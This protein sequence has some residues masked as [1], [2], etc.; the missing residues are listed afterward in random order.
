[1]GNKTV[2]CKHTNKTYQEKLNELYDNQFKL[3]SNIEEDKDKI[4]VECLRCNNN[5]EFSRSG[6]E[7]ECKDEKCPYC[8]IK[9]RENEIFKIVSGLYDNIIVN[10]ITYM[11]PEKFNVNFSCKKHGGSYDIIAK[12]IM[13]GQSLG[14][15][16]CP[17]C[18]KE[19]SNILRIERVQKYFPLKM[20]CG[21]I[22][23][24]LYAEI[25]LDTDKVMVHCVDQ[26]GYK[27][28]FMNEKLSTI[29]SSNYTS[30]LNKFFKR[31]SY[32]YENINNYCKINNID[33]KIENGNY[34][35]SGYAREKLPFK[36]SK[37]ETIITTWNAIQTSKLANRTD[38]EIVAIKN[39]KY[40]S[41]EKAIPI[42]LKK[43]KELK[44]PLLQ[45]DFEGIETSDNSIGIRVIWRIWGTFTNMIKELGL[46]EHDFYFK[47]N[48]K[49]YK[50]H[51][52]IM[53][54]IK[55]ACYEI[56]KENRKIIMISDLEKYTNM[57][58]NRLRKHCQK[59]G[60][61]LNKLVESYGY[62]IQ[63]TGNGMNYIFLDGEK[64]VS[65]YEYDF[66]NFLRENNL[67]YNK[68]YFRNIPYKTLDNEYSGNMNCDYLIILNNKK[69]YIELAGIL[70]NK[71]HQ[72]AYRNNIPIN[73][74]SKEI[75]R[76][77]LYQK[78]DIFE[79]N[80][81]DYYILLPDE[82]NENTYKRILEK[83]L[84]EVA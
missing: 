59:D 50:S 76:Q 17:E 74:K 18:R 36:N 43:Y 4:I 73:S 35:V 32:T 30:E 34:P 33:L 79:R 55:N 80:N 68:T 45:S 20:T 81:L 38:E 37:G 41:K 42:I 39:K 71:S 83:Y 9:N 57:S 63:S 31:N 2:K 23:E 44:R 25:D 53:D 19:A 77:K 75:Y 15:N 58:V 13:Y 6:I 51:E 47:P 62:K 40:M 16:L 21:D 56:S 66:S 60:T 54:S 28:K 11:S 26:N 46:P 10:S 27:Y 49:N 61:T 70:G 69:V 1:M 67:M 24:L 5:I 7:N 65:R 12:S 72:E 29:Q 48:A 8:K 64:V 82:I 84:K 78:R 3:I 22:L 52:E 14:K